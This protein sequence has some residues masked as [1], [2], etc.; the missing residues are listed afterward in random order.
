MRR[1]LSVE[2]LDRREVLGL[3]EAR[4]VALRVGPLLR[5]RRLRTRRLRLSARRLERPARLARRLEL[6]ARLGVRRRLG[7]A[8]RVELG[9]GGGA[10]RVRLLERRRHPPRALLERR[11]VLRPQL[12]LAALAA[13]ESGAERCRLLLCGLPLEDGTAARGFGDGDL[14]LDP[15]ELHRRRHPRR[16]ERLLELAL[17]SVGARLQLGGDRRLRLGR[18]GGGGELGLVLGEEGGGVVLRVLQLRAQ[19]ARVRLRVGERLRLLGELLRLL[20]LCRL[21]Q[22]AQR[23]E[24]GLGLG[25]G[26]LESADGRGVR[27]AH[28]LER[29]RLRGAHLRERRRLRGAHLRDGR[30]VRALL[31]RRLGCPARRLDLELGLGLGEGAR[32]LRARLVERRAQPRARRLG[33]L[34]HAP[35]LALGRA[36]RLRVRRARRLEDRLVLGAER[37]ELLG[38]RRVRL[39][40]RPRVRPLELR[41][42]RRERRRVLVGT[43]SLL[44]LEQRAHGGER[45]L[46][47]PGVLGGEDGVLGLEPLPCAQMR[48]LRA[49]QRR[50]VLNR[51]VVGARLGEDARVGRGA[52]LVRRLAERA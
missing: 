39:R 4:G 10:A 20:R 41:R 36:E 38:V 16:R 51:H 14:L 17:Q 28:L 48:R 21:E 26:G 47:R 31:L 43:L 30:R 6:G 37:G 2:R 32:S 23:G 29:R 22:L 45:R 12:A 52:R 1:L 24:L 5:G 27:V 25:L 13:G 19:R 9:L 15:L 33:S 40:E 18:L 8:H 3:E 34:E 50:R 49:L 44:R 11:L 35:V 42:R 46:V 7:L